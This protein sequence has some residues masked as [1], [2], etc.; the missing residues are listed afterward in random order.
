MKEAIR[1]LSRAVE[2]AP[3]LADAHLNLALAL[4]KDGAKQNAARHFSLYL[5]YEPNGP[6]ADFAKSRIASSRAASY[7]SPSGKLTPFRRKQ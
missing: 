6:W 4:E 3:A 5:R 1:R 7:G 2:L